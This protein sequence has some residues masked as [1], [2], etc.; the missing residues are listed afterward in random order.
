MGKRL[1]NVKIGCMSCTLTHVL[2]AGVSL[3]ASVPT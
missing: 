2:M 3:Q 1:C